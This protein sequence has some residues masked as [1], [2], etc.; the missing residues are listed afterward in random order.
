[1]RD[2]S[3]EIAITSDCIVGFPGEDDAAFE[4]SVKLISDIQFEGIF[5]FIYSPRKF[6]VAS[7]LLDVVPREVAIERLK[8]LQEVQKAI[9]LKKHRA[10]EGSTKEV[11]VEGPSKNSKDEVMGR[12]RTNKIVNFAG[13]LDMVGS[14]VNVGIVRGYANSLRGELRGRGQC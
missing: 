4:E 12:T 2:R 13:N 10:M 14:L 11:L 9:T 7:T 8:R 3:A 1:L 6:T 5:S